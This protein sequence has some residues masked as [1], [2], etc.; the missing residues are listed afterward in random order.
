MIVRFPL[1]L[2]LG[3]YKNY[4]IILGVNPYYGKQV[5]GQNIYILNKIDIPYN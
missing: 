3:Y 2:S 5:R 4:K 1:F